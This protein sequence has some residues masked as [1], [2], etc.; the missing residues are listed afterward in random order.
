MGRGG[1][2]TSKASSRHPAGAERF[3]RS[4]ALWS[5]EHDPAVWRSLAAAYP[6]VA[7]AV[8]A[9]EVVHGKGV[10]CDVEERLQELQTALRT[11]RRPRYVTRDEL[12]LVT[13]W[14]M[15]RNKARMNYAM[16]ADPRNGDTAVRR[17]SEEAFRLWEDGQW[18]RAFTVMDKPFKGVGPAT[19]SVLLSLVDDN[20]PFYGEEAIRAITDGREPGYSKD[21]YRAFKKVMDMKAGALSASLQKDESPLTPVELE[22]ALFSIA[23]IDFLR[24]QGVDLELENVGEMKGGK[25]RE[26]HK[27]ETASPQV[28][29]GAK[30]TSDAETDRKPS[31]PRKKQKSRGVVDSK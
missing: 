15:S 24:E 8:T 21:N 18:E 16:T 9:G 17:V 11:Q 19:V 25:K 6:R 29:S 31:R 1:I 3:A 12:L 5:S 4:S 7:V 26:S 27:Q 14:K 13:D 22:H 23:H 30:R 20:L 28:G 10:W 2:L